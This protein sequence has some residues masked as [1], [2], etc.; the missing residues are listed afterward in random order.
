[1]GVFLSW[2]FRLDQRRHIA[3][4]HARHDDVEQDYVGLEL[5]WPLARRPP[6]SFPRGTS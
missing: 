1:M 5:P 3:A 4:G 2:G 6:A